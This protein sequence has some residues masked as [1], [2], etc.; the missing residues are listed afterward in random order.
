MVSRVGS[1][2]ERSRGVGAHQESILVD[3][4]RG[5]DAGLGVG[6]EIER[7]AARRVHAQRFDLPPLSKLSDQVAHGDARQQ[8][9]CPCEE[10]ENRA[11]ELRI[12]AVVTRRGGL[13]LAVLLVDVLTVRLGRGNDLHGAYRECGG[14]QRREPLHVH[15]ETLRYIGRLEDAFE[16][17]VRSHFTGREGGMTTVWRPRV[18]IAVPDID[19]ADADENRRDESTKKGTKRKRAPP[20]KGPCE[21]GVKPRSACK[22]CSACPHGRRRRQC[23]E[24]G[25]FAF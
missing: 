16:K 4:R 1:I 7:L 18:R 6:E 5:E 9:A 3:D 8:R 2:R 23:K 22:V 10:V 14:E 12:G 20:T 13:K 17:F 15:E 24:C 21:H 11:T 19:G 25:G